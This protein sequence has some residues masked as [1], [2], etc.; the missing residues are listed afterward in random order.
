MVQIHKAK[1][2][3]VWQLMN[4]WWN[5]HNLY[6][7][8]HLMASSIFLFIQCGLTLDEPLWGD[9]WDIIFLNTSKRDI[10]YLTVLKT[11][12]II[13]NICQLFLDIFVHWNHN[14]Y[15]LLFKN[16]LNPSI[17]HL[18]GVLLYQI[19]WI[20]AFSCFLKIYEISGWKK[21]P[22]VYL[23]DTSSKIRCYLIHQG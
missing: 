22:S 3:D 4:L 18:Y 12:L 23:F 5:M 16:Y 21:I 15:L 17:D 2:L 20:F 9:T 14:Q 7:T 13:S 10:L 1:F 6:V 11:F 19:I 8:E